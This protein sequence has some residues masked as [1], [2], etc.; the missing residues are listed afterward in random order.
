MRVI[1]FAVEKKANNN[2]VSRQGS[3]L[4]RVAWSCRRFVGRHLL[5]NPKRQP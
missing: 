2:T 4:E 3:N 5:S 1:L